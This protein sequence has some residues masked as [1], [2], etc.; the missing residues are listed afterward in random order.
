MIIVLVLSAF[1]EARAWVGSL[2]RARLSELERVVTSDYALAEA[3]GRWEQDHKPI[4][5]DAQLKALLQEQVIRLRM[6]AIE[7]PWNAAAP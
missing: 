5:H 2:V 4:Q 1:R 7:D 6:Q 3:A